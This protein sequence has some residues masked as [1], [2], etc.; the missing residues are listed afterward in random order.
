VSG[1]VA[2]LDRR[3]WVVS[4]QRDVIAG[5]GVP[6]PIGPYSAGVRLGDVLF[7]SGQPGVDPATAEP[8]GTA[9]GDQARQAFRNLEAVLRVGGSRPELVANVT[10]LVADVAGF[11]ELNEIFAEVFPSDPPARMTMQVPLPM[12]LLVSVGCVAGVDHAG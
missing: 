7:V 8:V 9:F 3:R 12:G 6:K 10:V 5:P 4:P 11:A 2:V 1:T